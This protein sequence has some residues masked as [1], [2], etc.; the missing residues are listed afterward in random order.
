MRNLE[1][2]GRSEVLIV[3]WM[4]GL[5]VSG[6]GSKQAAEELKPPEAFL[7]KFG[8]CP[9]ALVGENIQVTFAVG[10][11][12]FPKVV[13][14]G[15]AFLI[16]WWDMRGRFPNLYTIRM[17]REGYE[18][19]TLEKL[20]NQASAK[21][22]DIA[23]DGQETRM[24][25]MENDQ[26]LGTR[27]RGRLPKVEV[28]SKSGGMPAAGPWGAAAWVD[29]GKLF[30]RSDGMPRGREG[31][32]PVVIATGGIQDPQIAYNGVFFG[33]VWSESVPGGRRIVLQR[34]SVKGE[35]LGSPVSVSASDGMSKKPTIAWANGRF[36]VAWTTTAASEAGSRS[37]YRLF[38]AV[39]LD[40]GE[41][42][43]F[44][45]KLDFRGSVDEVALAATG[46][47][48]ALAWVGTR[49]NGGSAVFMQR[50]DLEG[51]PLEETIEVSDGV[52]LTCSQPDLAW[53]GQGY[54]IVWHDD[55]EQVESEIYFAYVSCGKGTPKPKKG[56]D[57]RSDGPPDASVSSEEPEEPPEAQDGLGELKEV[58]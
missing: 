36:A 35:P 49:G 26:V 42:P 8:R 52:P 46:E 14:D 20:P 3:A 58:F 30:F 1:R 55:R 57:A 41:M 2:P 37:Q 24:V 21:H 7:P 10:E 4:L 15:E 13:W 29:G 28:L 32:E 27:L 12:N 11:S 5:L 23:F 44:I 25:W 54:G 45:R 16:A 48:Y 56:P 50:L 18:V 9:G 19:G 40:G 51:T 34:V 17:S 6:C 31:I 38:F 43:S 53:D 22:H 33:V 39:V 47:E